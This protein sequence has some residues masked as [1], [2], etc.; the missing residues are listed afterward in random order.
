MTQPLVTMKEVCGIYSVTRFTV[1]RWVREGILPAPI[2]M[3]RL[4]R[5]RPQDIENAV[6][7]AAERN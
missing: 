4:L 3:G 2:K 6:Q 1:R 5:W 7:G